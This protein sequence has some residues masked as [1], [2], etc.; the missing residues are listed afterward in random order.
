MIGVWEEVDG[1]DRGQTV[2]WN[3][4]DT[5]D[6]AVLFEPDASQPSVSRSDSL[7]ILNPSRN[8]SRFTQHRALTPKQQHFAC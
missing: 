4:D 1:K 5:D 8:R 7:H 2:P 3:V 6:V